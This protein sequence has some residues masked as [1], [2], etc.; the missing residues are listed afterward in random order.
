MSIEMVLFAATE[1]APL[2]REHPTGLVAARE[3]P[4]VGGEHGTT[5]RFEATTPSLDPGPLL[6]RPGLPRAGLAADRP[7]ECSR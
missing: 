2:L 5:P 7:G 3:G 4:Y 6:S 1:P